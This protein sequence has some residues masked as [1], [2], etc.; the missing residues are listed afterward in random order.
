MF[1]TLSALSAMRLGRR[2]GTRIDA[3]GDLDRASV[4]AE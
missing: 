1:A 4:L 2:C 3:F